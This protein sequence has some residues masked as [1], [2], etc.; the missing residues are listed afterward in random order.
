MAPP[1]EVTQYHYGLIRAPKGDSLFLP[2][3]LLSEALSF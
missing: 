3:L 2:S 1:F